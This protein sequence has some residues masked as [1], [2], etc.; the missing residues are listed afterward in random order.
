MT[1]GWELFPGLPVPLLVCYS[2][3][4]ADGIALEAG[5]SCLT[6][7]WWL[8]PPLRLPTSPTTHWPC[9][10][11]LPGVAVL[12]SPFGLHLP[13]WAVESWSR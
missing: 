12:L 9:E 4:L 11:R 6:L 3:G 8:G 5:R 7:W 2:C 10:P 13:A 1:G